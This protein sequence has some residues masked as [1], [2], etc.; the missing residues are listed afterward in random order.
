[1]WDTSLDKKIWSELLNHA[2]SLRILPQVRLELEPWLARHHNSRAARAL[3][4]NNPNLSVLPPPQPE[5]VEA[6]ALSYYV[7]LLLIRRRVGHLI[8][9]RLQESLGR[10]PTEAEVNLATQKAVGIRG[11]QLVHKNRKKV[12]VDKY[13]TDECL[14]YETIASGIRTGRPTLLLTRDRDLLEQ[15]YKL[16]W[17]LD[18]HYRAMLI[19]NE[20]AEQPAL[21]KQLPPPDIGEWAQF[22]QTTHSLL[23]ATPDTRMNDFLPSKPHFVAVECWVLGKNGLER[24]VFG[25]ET[26]MADLLTVK[27]RTRG[28]VSERLDGRNAHTWLAPLPIDANLQH[29]TAIAEDRYIQMSDGSTRLGVFDV[30]HTINTKERYSHVQT[31]WHPPS[32]PPS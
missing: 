29:S 31:P 8:E 25:A 32:V 3:T 27:G 30:M 12:G 6:A 24:L 19:A 18:T 28:L 1:M 23:W 4:G 11:L 21:F 5:T 7:D 26:E 15:F 22:F 9:R 17:L 10:L 16:C 2:G 14:V 13:A 20:F